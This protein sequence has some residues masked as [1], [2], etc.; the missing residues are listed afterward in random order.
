VSKAYL[1]DPAEPLLFRVSH[2]QIALLLLFRLT[3]LT[4]LFLSVSLDC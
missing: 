4:L 1:F 3:S 2:L